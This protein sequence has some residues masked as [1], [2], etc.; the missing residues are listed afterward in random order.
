MQV[1]VTGAAGFIGYSLCNVLVKK[2]NLKVIGI[3]KINSKKKSIFNDRLHI[4]KK[5]KNFK[6]KKINICNY[7]D[8]KKV[9][10][11]NHFTFVINL[12]A[13]AGVRNSIEN[14][15]N[16]IKTNLVGFYN[17]LKLSKEM[18]IP[19]LIFA[20]SSSVYGEAKKYPTSENANTDNP[21]SFYAST[22]K[23]NELIA[24]S[25]SKMFN[26]QITGLRFF[27]VYGPY[28]RPDMAIFKF[29]KNI[30]NK[31]EIIL[32]SGGKHIRD[33]T[34]IEDVVEDIMSIILNK[35]VLSKKFNIYNIGGGSRT[36]INQIVKMIEKIT[37]TKSK[38]IYDKKQ[39]GDV[40]KTY[41]NN[42]KFVKEFRRKKYTSINDGLLL[43]FKWYKDYFN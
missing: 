27:T 37:K 7:K 32:F 31:K 29:F 4:L 8:L 38:T 14:P 22:K 17:I 42:N 40:D 11:S 30:L 41:C 28:G 25:Y 15:D 10:I 1:L 34:Y 19:H 2:N 36:S 9:F 3:D 12:A 21:I 16:F 43:F 20:S 18:N 39:N 13:E 26:M 33:F 5:N 23:S 24:Y 6:Y 35:K